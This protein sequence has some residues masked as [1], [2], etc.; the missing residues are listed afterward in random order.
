MSLLQSRLQDWKSR[1]FLAYGRR[2]YAR[3]YRSYRR[4]QLHDY[5]HRSLP[6][7]KLSDGWGRWLE[8]R[9]V[10]YPWFFS[11]L[12]GTPGRL[13]DAGSVLN[14]GDVLSHERL[15][16]KEISIFTLAPES[17]CYW[18][19]GISYVYGDLRNCC[20]RDDYFDWVVSLSTL[21]HVGM[22]NTRFYTHD[23]SKKECDPTSHLQA[24]LELRRVLKP[25]GALYVSL[26]FGRPRNY[27]WLQVFDLAAVRNILDV[28]QPASSR[29]IY[30]RYSAASGWQLSS[31]DECADARYFDSSQ[32]QV[33]QGELIAAE[34]VV[35]LELL[36]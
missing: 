14:Y 19:R 33:D 36:K 12:P 24:V 32:S 17:E 20:F 26:P 15:R 28:F 3:G 27:G 2:P 13:L 7:G 4:I 18:H 22:D 30:F 25:N 21:E 8:E 35:C 31:P 29:E 5:I 9:V 6:E 1:V 10:E 23:H 11:R 16:N 34:A